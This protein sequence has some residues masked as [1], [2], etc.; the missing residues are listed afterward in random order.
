M[1]ARLKGRR[2]Q[3][4]QFVGDMSLIGDMC[5]R[6]TGKIA[7]DPLAWTS[8]ASF[9]AWDRLRWR[10]RYPVARLTVCSLISFA[11]SKRQRHSAPA[12]R[13]C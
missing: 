7:S 11:R 10:P 2:F 1:D 13:I 12:G 9:S 6:V 3:Q 5:Q 4:R 8:S